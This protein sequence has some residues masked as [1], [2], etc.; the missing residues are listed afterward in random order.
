MFHHKF[1]ICHT[2]MKFLNYNL[3]ILF[4]ILLKGKVFPSLQPAFAVFRYPFCG[5]SPA[6]P[7]HYLR[8]SWETL[9]KNCKINT[10]PH[11]NFSTTSPKLCVFIQYAQNFWNFVHII[12]IRGIFPLISLNY[13]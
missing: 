6:T 2:T 1:S 5:S 10:L 12:L 7:P 4:V 13:L 9:S 8:L 11:W 3:R